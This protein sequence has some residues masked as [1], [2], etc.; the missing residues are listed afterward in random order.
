MGREPSS[1][2][3]T[4]PE[5]G[6][7]REART[8]RRG[9]RAPGSAGNGVASAPRPSRNGNNGQRSAARALP[10]QEWEPPDLQE[11]DPGSLGLESPGLSNDIIDL[12]AGT[13]GLDKPAVVS[14][15][16]KSRLRIAQYSVGLLAFV[17][18]GSFVTL[19]LGRSIDD[20]SRLLDIIFAPIIAVV[21]A[22]V[23]FY[24]RSSGSL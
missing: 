1:A 16:E 11:R 9:S 4:P 23:A 13:P 12:P 20:L 6:P 3:E 14:H 17:V 24:Y 22:A 7:P 19:W 15:M 8:V 21:A 2:G 10:E 5:T 18:V